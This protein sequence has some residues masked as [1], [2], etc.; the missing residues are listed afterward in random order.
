MP[1][2]PIVEYPLSGGGSLPAASAAGQTL[3]SSGAG[4]TYTAQVPAIS[5]IQ[6]QILAAPAASI[7]FSAIPGTFKHLKLV[8]QFNTAS[9]NLLI[10]FNGDSTTG[11]YSYQ[12][13]YGNTI[14]PSTAF[15]ASTTGILVGFPA[16]S[17]EV[18]IP[19][20]TGSLQLNVVSKFAWCIA[21]GT[22]L[23]SGVGGG[24][25]TGTLPVTSIT[26][27]TGANMTAGTIFSLYGLS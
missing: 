19:G 15:N 10:Q 5:L 13:S 6:E 12:V 17:V 22:N 7:T 4:T 27:S 23:F 11:H 16:G 1:A 3:V 8:G 26:L 25:W 20:Y 14:T 9:G 21:G 2:N 18:D 24:A